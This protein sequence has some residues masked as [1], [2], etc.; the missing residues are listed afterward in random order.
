MMP[1][2]TR[3]FRYLDKV[4]ERH[5]IFISW[6]DHSDLLKFSRPVPDRSSSAVCRCLEGW[7]ELESIEQDVLKITYG[8]ETIVK[9]ATYSLCSTRAKIGTTLVDPN[10]WAG[11]ESGS[12]LSEWWLSA[13]LI[14]TVLTSERPLLKKQCWRLRRRRAWERR[15]CAVVDWRR[16]GKRIISKVTKVKWK[17]WQMK[18]NVE[19][20]KCLIKSTENFIQKWFFC[21]SNSVAIYRS[22]WRKF[23]ASDFCCPINQVNTTQRSGVNIW[24][25]CHQ[26][27]NLTTQGLSWLHEP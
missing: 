24:N 26:R 19:V 10:H 2:R 18:N 7:P 4:T 13:G 1:L 12:N 22:I 8:M 9:M 5:A 21:D 6:L 3:L 20:A 15:N 25:S 11:V 14:P 23:S 17:H 16:R 27:P